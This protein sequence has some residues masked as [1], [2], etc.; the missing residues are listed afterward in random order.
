MT[1]EKTFWLND[2][3]KWVALAWNLSESLYICGMLGQ[4]V[5]FPRKSVKDED[6]VQTYMVHYMEDTYRLHEQKKNEKV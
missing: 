6:Y 1:H 5:T 2:V 4:L 3:N